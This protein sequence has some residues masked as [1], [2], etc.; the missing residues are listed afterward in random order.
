MASVESADRFDNVAPADSPKAASDKYNRHGHAYSAATLTNKA[1][2]TLASG[3]VVALDLTNDA[4][5][6][7][8]DAVGSLRPYFV[9]QATITA[10]ASGEF[11]YEGVV[12]VKAQGSIARG[13]W[14]RKSNTAKAVETT[15]VMVAASRRP[16]PGA[17]GFALAAASGGTVTT[18]W[19]GGTGVP[20]SNVRDPERYIEVYEDFFGDN[21]SA[22]RANLAII[23]FRHVWRCTSEDLR[24]ASGK[25][26]LVN[27]ATDGARAQATL[28]YRAGNAKANIIQPS[29]NPILTVRWAQT[30]TGAGTRY[31]G[32]STAALITDGPGIYFRHT[33][34]GNIIAVCRVAGPSE[35]TLDTG[36][37]AAD[38]TYH[39]GKI[40]VTGTT[41]VEVFIDGVS[42]GT[43][44]TNIPS[45]LLGPSAGS[46]TTASAADGLTV[47]FIHVRADR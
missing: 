14:V 38:G 46:N 2:E 35:T 28:R 43:I 13:E 10:D 36:I 37:A 44:A 17:L 39:T 26:Q 45:S 1:G 42:K 8:W 41:S 23:Q 19:T 27:N 34:G 30:G 40:V 20:A 11:A 6:C 21:A 4:S 16:P 18:Y 32:L 24:N 12:S 7:K 47:E 5:V 31:I 25:L 29:Q 3:D 33:A 9:A 22:A 15:G